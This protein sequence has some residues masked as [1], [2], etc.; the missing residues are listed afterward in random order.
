MKIKRCKIQPYESEKTRVWRNETPQIKLPFSVSYKEHFNLEICMSHISYQ[1]LV[2]Y[3]EGLISDSEKK[4]VES[5]LST[6][7]EKC[8]DDLLYIRGI[9]KAMLNDAEEVKVKAPENIVKR[10]LLLFP[11]YQKKYGFG[12]RKSRIKKV[13]EYIEQLIAQ[14]LIEPQPV[15]IREDNQPSYIIQFKID[16][17]SAFVNI[18]IEPKLNKKALAIRGN[19]LIPN[20]TDWQ[21]SNVYLLSNNKIATSTKMNEDC[22]FKFDFILSGEYGLSIISDKLKKEIKIEKVKVVCE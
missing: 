8:I 16:D 19:L 12:K 6:N 18:R 17:L 9:A 7:C 15:P 3:N 2:G 22:H 4:K 21:N 13:K 5:H 10:A 14:P 11:I 20:L 1:L